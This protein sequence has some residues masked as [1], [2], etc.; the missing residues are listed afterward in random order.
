MSDATYFPALVWI[1]PL[2]VFDTLRDEELSLIASAR[3]GVATALVTGLLVAMGALPGTGAGLGALF[4]AVGVAVQVALAPFLFGGVLWVASRVLGARESS[5]EQAVSVPAVLLG[6]YPFALVLQAVTLRLGGGGMMALVGIALPLAIAI[7]FVSLGL[8]RTLGANGI[9]TSILGSLAGLFVLGLGALAVVVS[10]TVVDLDGEAGHRAWEAEK[11]RV[12]AEAAARQAAE[13][14]PSAPAHVE[15]PP[16]PAPPPPAGTVLVTPRPPPPVAV[17]EE[18]P[19]PPP[20]SW[21]IDCE[22]VPSGAMIEE[23]ST[24]RFL[25]TTPRKLAFPKELATMRL[26]LRHGSSV[27]EA[28]VTREGDPFLVVAMPEGEATPP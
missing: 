23:A 26:R 25:G 20:G 22:T 5:Y 18:E 9:A 3:V 1:R 17:V 14:E 16:E 8:V 2:E 10:A 27:T 28:T 21:L 6:L 11:A 7:G 15:A 12:I 4:A 24:G 19:P 13:E